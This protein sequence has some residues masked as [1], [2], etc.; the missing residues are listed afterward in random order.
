VNDYF[1]INS[2]PALNRKQKFRQRF[3]NRFNTQ[4]KTIFLGAVI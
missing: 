2:L 1:N 3:E 4:K